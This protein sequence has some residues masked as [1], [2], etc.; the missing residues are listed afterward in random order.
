MKDLALLV[1]SRGRPENV[2]RLLY[3]V[4]RLTGVAVGKLVVYLGLDDDDDVDAYLRQHNVD[5]GLSTGLLKVVTGE[6]KTLA[7]WTNHLGQLAAD[8]D[9]AEFLASLGDDHTPITFQWDVDLMAAIRRQD[10]PGYAYGNDLFQGRLM[11]TA[12]VQ[13]VLTYRALGWV[14]QPTL[15][16]MYVDNVILSLGMAAN[17]IT[18]V[19]SVVV[20]HRHPLAHKAKWDASYKE[21]N[22]AAS[23]ADDGALFEKWAAEQLAADADMLKS[24]TWTEGG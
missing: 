8:V 13:H 4:A 21:T 7:E 15:R 10:G 22:S 12:W 6:R 11:P 9:H 23:F 3:Q 14:M 24:M 1:P 17:R 20:E 16:H 2:D 18:Y 19:P 5:A